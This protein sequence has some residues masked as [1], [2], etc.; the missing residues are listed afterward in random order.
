MSWLVPFSA[1]TPEQQDA[2]CLDDNSHKIIIGGPGAGK[3]LVLLHR[4]SYFFEKNNKNKDAVHF[5]VY[6]TSLKDFIKTSLEIFNIPE[7]CVTTFDKW[8]VE[9]YK[10]HISNSLP[11]ITTGKYKMP[12]FAKIRSI[13]HEQISTKKINIPQFS[14]I[15]LDEAQDMDKQAIEIICCIT[16]HLT[17][18]MDEK[19]QLYDDRLE[20]SEILKILNI[21]KH[22][23][24]L[25]SAFRC[26]PMVTELASNFIQDDNRRKEF[27]IQ[28]KNASGDRHKPLLYLA[29]DFENEKKKLAELIHMRLANNERIAILFPQQKFVYGYA[30]GL[31]ELGITVDTNSRN[32]LDFSNGHPKALTY[33]EAK[34]LTFDCIFMPRLDTFAFTNKMTS[35]LQSL[36]FVGISR[37]VSWVYMSSV[38][39]KQIS[40]ISDLCAKKRDYL[41]VQYNKNIAN[42]TSENHNDNIENDWLDDMY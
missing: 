2:V 3:S 29:S 16:K 40:I 15:L 5:F 27:K 31:E 42:L 22:N 6:T 14:A 23:V 36:I 19:Q 9:T 37:A 28:A 12:D 34:G 25:L 10:K 33:H 35:R 17:V 20:E 30:T 38:E 7:Q 11:Y 26:N 13:L 8:C 21:K 39:G 1:L 24:S 4:L 18:A 41:E 32:G